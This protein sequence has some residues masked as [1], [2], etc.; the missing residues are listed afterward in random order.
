MKWG[1]LIIVFVPLLVGLAAGGPGGLV[2]AVVLFLAIA[3][4]ASPF[5][6]F[7][8]IMSALWDEA[9]EEAQ[10]EDDAVPGRLTEEQ[11]VWDE[12]EWQTIQFTDGTVTQGLILLDEDDDEICTI[13]LAD[14]TVTQ[15]IILDRSGGV[16]DVQEIGAV[17][18]NW[19]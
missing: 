2:L 11:D 10:T 17:P 5:F 7:G 14:G 18:K 16:T 8:G 15:A 12:E 3:I 4:P 13:Q 9:Q 1:C 19:A 6:L